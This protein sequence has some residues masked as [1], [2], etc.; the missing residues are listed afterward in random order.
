MATTWT[1]G[2]V[3]RGLV[4]IVLLAVALS[5]VFAFPLFGGVRSGEP[6]PD[7]SVSHVTLPHDE[8]IV[9]H[10]TNNA[11]E[12]ATVSQVLVDEAYWNFIM[13][14]G[15]PGDT[16]LAPMESTTVTLPYHWT[17]G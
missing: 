2:R 11:P 5:A 14:D 7:V 6:L 15:D 16:S 8:E 13:G 1:A 3:L 4:P 10:V 17:A 12:P 9:L